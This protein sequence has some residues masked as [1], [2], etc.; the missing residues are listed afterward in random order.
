M[1]GHLLLFLGMHIRATK[2]S[3]LT[4][5]II[6]GEEK[7][8]SDVIYRVFQKVKFFTANNKLTSYFQNHF[9]LPQGHFWTKFT[10]PLK[11]TQQV[12]LCLLVKRLTLGSLLRIPRITE[13]IG[14]HGNAMPPHGTSTLSSKNVN[15]LT[16]SFSSHIFCTFTA[17]L[18]RQ[19][20]SNKGSN[21]H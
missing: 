12:I 10:L 6:A 19:G 5:T 1:E 13:N 11:L 18:L 21:L 14:R 9:Q 7:D 16:S 20:P 3:H 8:M 4:P 17:R 2:A 15:K